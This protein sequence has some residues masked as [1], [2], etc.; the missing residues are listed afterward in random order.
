MG[1][2]WQSTEFRG[3][4][5]YKHPTRK[6]GKKFDR[7]F[8][9]RYAANGRM[10][11][12]GYGWESKGHTAAGAAKLLDELKRAA[13]TGEG[14]ATLAERREG[15][16]QK[17]AAAEAAATTFA[18]FWKNKYLPQ[19]EADKHRETIVHE[20]SVFNK[21]LSPLF[22][23]LPLKSISPLR[24]ETLKSQMT[25]AGLSPRSVQYALAITRQVFNEARRRGVFTG[26]N[27]AGKVRFPKVDNRRLRFLT[28]EEAAALLAELERTDPEAREMALLSLHCGL[29]AS[30]I[31]K[32]TWQDLDPGRDLIAVKDTKSG[33]SRFAHMT[34]GVKEMLLSKDI[35]EPSALLYPGPGGALRREVP[36]TVKAAI[37][38]LGFNEGRT[39]PRDRLVFHSLR[40]SFASWLVQQGVDLYTVR[41]LMGHSTLA[42]TQ[43]YAHLAPEN[44]RR[45]IDTLEKILSNPPAEAA[46]AA[47]EGK[48]R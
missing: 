16:R 2:Q 13:R 1:V 47:E 44:T 21:W 33:R 19:A 38:A 6:H 3:V 48:A 36:R 10:I 11:E 26:E 23:A 17:K 29:R 46:P 28:P 4:R 42:M 7:Y 24:L 8:S 45:A 35:G 31:F 15:A 12:E 39:D 34:A 25:K 14:A 9:I 43:R 30:E 20:R 27:P 37:D 41:E 5:F 40:H 32:L 18:D 22:G